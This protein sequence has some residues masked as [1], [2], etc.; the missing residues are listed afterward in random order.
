MFVKLTGRKCVVV[1]GGPV[2]EGKIESLLHAGANVTIVSPGLTDSL[3][4]LHR[5]GQFLWIRSRFDVSQ[6]EGAF[7]VIAATSDDATNE[8]VY[9]AANDSGILCNAVDQ[10]ARCHFYFPAVAQRGAL[11]IAVSTAGLSPSLAQRLRKH[12]EKEFGPEYEDWL[13]WLGVVRESLMQRQ[14]SFVVRK[15]LL[16]Y[17]ASENGFDHWQAARSRKSALQEVA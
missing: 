14:V 9:R 1:G 8:A 11:Q 15:R 4:Q 16:A 2:A 5:C 10:P 17:L 12:F 6:I 3:E 7:L 13:Y